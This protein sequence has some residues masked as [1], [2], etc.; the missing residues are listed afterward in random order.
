MDEHWILL[1]M[2]L[3]QAPCIL[4]GKP[5]MNR[6]EFIPKDPRQFGQR[7]PAPGKIRVAFYALCEDHPR[8]KKTLRR[9]ERILA[10]GT[11]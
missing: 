4:C 1:H 9:V 6:G 11:N 5:T 3:P 2:T 7:L 10:S 8:N